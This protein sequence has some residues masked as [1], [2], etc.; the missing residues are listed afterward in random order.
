MA[1]TNEELET[2]KQ[3]FGTNPTGS[4]TINASPVTTQHTF[5]HNDDTPRIAVKVEK[6]SR[7]VNWEVSISNA[8]DPDIALNLLRETETRIK[9][10][11]EPKPDP[12]PEEEEP[13]PL[14]F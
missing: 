6:N 2:L 8:T 11:Y 12:E 4:Y 1:Y 14:P 7:G 3:K 9:A 5:H 10:M 13:L